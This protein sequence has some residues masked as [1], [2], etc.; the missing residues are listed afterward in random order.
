MRPE[1]RHIAVLNFHFV[2][3]ETSSLK[4]ED[5][6]SLRVLLEGPRGM[7]KDLS[8]CAQARVPPRLP[9]CT[10]WQQLL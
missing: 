5:L 8:G 9:A 10:H 1:T 2:A 7:A 3:L 4:E 6:L